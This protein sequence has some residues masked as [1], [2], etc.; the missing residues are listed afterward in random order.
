MHF[1]SSSMKSVKQKKRKTDLAPGTL[2]FSR[3]TPQH[4]NTIHMSLGFASGTL[5]CFLFL[6]EIPLLSLLDQNRDWGD[7]RLRPR[8]G[9]PRRSP[10]AEPTL[11]RPT[12]QPSLA[13]DGLTHQ[14][15]PPCLP[16]H[17]GQRERVE[18]EEGEWRRMWRRVSDGVESPSGCPNARWSTSTC[19]AMVVGAL[20]M[21]ATSM[22]RVALWRISSSTWRVTVWPTRDADLGRIWTEFGHGPKTKFALL[23]TLS[24]FD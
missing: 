8:Q 22:T 1:Q 24:N 10:S 16:V 20:C 2:A 19:A 13:R 14:W 21:V 11:K 23:L 7:G 6:P 3:I 9:R 18:R 15:W 17:G 12:G 4:I 5:S